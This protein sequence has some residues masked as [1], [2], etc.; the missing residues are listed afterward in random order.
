MKKFQ[1]P[2]ERVREF[3]RLQLEM[4]EA[5]LE[6]LF[7]HLGELDAREREVEA[8][9]RQAELDLRWTAAE[10]ALDPPQLD[11]IASYGEFSRRAIEDIARERK[12]TQVE[13]G[14]QRLRVL[15]ANQS[16]EILEKLR[17]RY[18]THWQAEVDHEIETVAAE[19]YLARWNRG[20]RFP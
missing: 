12:Q 10:G 2:L 16:A 11:A 1:F 15:K 14:Q 20:Q 9:L 19:N 7:G 3:R 18:R 13:I 6:R 17:K 5:R 4:E 8:A